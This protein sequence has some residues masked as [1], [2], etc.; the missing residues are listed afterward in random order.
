MK[1]I[2]D[3]SLLLHDEMAMDMAGKR[4]GMS[5]SSALAFALMLFLFLYGRQRYPRIVI[6]FDEA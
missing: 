6:G 1:H 5:G 2:V 3:L 4:K